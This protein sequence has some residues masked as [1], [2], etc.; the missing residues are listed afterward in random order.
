MTYHTCPCCGRSWRDAA[1]MRAETRPLGMMPGV[2]GW[3]ELALCP[4]GDS[5]VVEVHP[6]TSRDQDDCPETLRATE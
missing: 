1:H 2:D 6:Y 3:L 5:R 4:C